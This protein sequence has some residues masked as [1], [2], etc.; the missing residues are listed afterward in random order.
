MFEKDVSF[1]TNNYYKSPVGRLMND[2]AIR[3]E[4]RVFVGRSPEYLYFNAT[5]SSLGTARLSYGVFGHRVG[6]DEE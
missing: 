1:N 5:Q 4:V 3:G 2:K 6:T